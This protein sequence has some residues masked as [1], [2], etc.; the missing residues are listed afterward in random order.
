VRQWR[1]V[2][3]VGD[4]LADGDAFDPGYGDYVAERGLGDVGSLQSGE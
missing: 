4:G 3:R 1:G 2:L